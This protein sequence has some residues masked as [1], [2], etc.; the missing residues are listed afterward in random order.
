M[1]PALDQGPIIEQDTVR[2]SHRD[3]IRR[4]QAQRT[5]LRKEIN[6]KPRRALVFGTKDPLPMATKP[7]FLD[8]LPPRIL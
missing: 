7:S 5:G 1:I 4:S 8:D 3:S 6:V 2:I